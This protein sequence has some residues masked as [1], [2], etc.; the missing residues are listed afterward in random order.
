MLSLQR[1]QRVTTQ[2]VILKEIDGLR[3]IAIFFVVFSHIRTVFFSETGLDATLPLMHGFANKIITS[4]NGINGVRIFFGLSGFILAYPF[5]MQGAT[6]NIKDYFARRV[7]RLEPTYL[8]SLIIYF[9]AMVAIK[10]K[11]LFVSFAFSVIYLHSLVFQK[12]SEI[13]P[14]TWSLEVEVQ[15]YLFFPVLLYFFQQFNKLS[16]FLSYGFI[17]VVICFGIYNQ[18]TA[19]LP[20]KTLLSEIQY[21]LTGFLAANIIRN[22]FL[23]LKKVN[24]KLVA[25]LL[26]IVVVLLFITRVGD[27]S[28]FNQVAFVLLVFVLFMLVLI[29]ASSFRKL[30]TTNLVYLTG[31][32]CYT[33]YLYH[34]AS[35]VLISPPYIGNVLKPD[36]FSFLLFTVSGLVLIWLSSYILYVL[37]EKPFMLRKWYT[38]P[39]ILR[40]YYQNLFSKKRVINE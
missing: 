2:N 16:P 19:I 10:G 5:F 15:Y 23:N 21:F 8:I 35:L 38:D 17:F 11:I 27:N 4:D 36:I 37:F 25:F 24:P 6:F 33:I 32:M 3:F 14:I 7:S 18:H 29:P 30:L 28:I 26:C 13:N 34:I 31:G 39:V 40:N 22:K 9:F 20:Y 12:P 1:L